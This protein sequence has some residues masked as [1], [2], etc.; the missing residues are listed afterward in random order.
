MVME[1]DRDTD[2]E[3]GTDMDDCDMDM[4]SGTNIWICLGHETFENIV[5]G[6]RY[7]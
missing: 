3:M 2:M 6:Y 5:I 1:T 4:D 7:R